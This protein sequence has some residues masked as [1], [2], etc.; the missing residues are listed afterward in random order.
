MIFISCKKEGT[1]EVPA[2]TTPSL[3]FMSGT[4]YVSS[5]TTLEVNEFFKVGV[6]GSKNPNSSI[7]I[8]TFKVVREFEGAIEVVH[9]ENDI[10][11]PNLFWESNEGT[12]SEVGEEKWTFTIKDYNGIT[13]EIS[14]LI[15]TVEQGTFAPAIGFIEGIDYIY[16]DLSLYS[17]STFKV[18]I[19][20]SSNANTGENIQH[21]IVKREFINIT[22]TVYEESDINTATYMWEDSLTYNSSVGDEIFTFIVTD[23][24]GCTNE[25]SFVVTKTDPPY[26]PVFS[27][28]YLI[29]NQGNLDFLDFYITCVTDDWEM[30]KIIVSYPAGLGSET[31]TG[32]GHITP[33][34]SPFTFSNYF[35]KLGGTWTFTISGNIKSGVHLN[36]SFTS[37]CSV[38]VSG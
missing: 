36:Q 7:N 10:G 11:E 3:I 33:A 32:N 35:L 26:I 20:A 9:E 25:I 6:M 2:D 14:L 18:G 37:I 29:V 1:E 12:N 8:A 19:T 22:N 16:E 30:T 31:Y 15:T 23:M 24:A 34:G 21:F 17:D 38:V 13:K 27:P 4:E 28:T 5:D